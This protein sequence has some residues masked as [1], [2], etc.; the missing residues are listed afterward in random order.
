MA[1]VK[2]RLRRAVAK[3]WPSL[4]KA[5]R[6]GGGSRSWREE[7]IINGYELTLIGFNS[8]YIDSNCLKPS[9]IR[10]GVCAAKACLRRAGCVGGDVDLPEQPRKQ[11]VANK[12]P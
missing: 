12:P 5:R 1:T 9:A 6:V 10:G 3:S 8:Q 11:I 2:W 4:A 7:R